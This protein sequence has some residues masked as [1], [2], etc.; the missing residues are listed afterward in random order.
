MRPFGHEG[1]VKIL[2][3]LGEPG[4][5]VK[6]LIERLQEYAPPNSAHADL[7]PWHPKFL[8]KT[9]GLTASTLEELG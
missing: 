2:V 7:D 9:Y 5:H 3:E 4:F 6:W 8:R 1:V